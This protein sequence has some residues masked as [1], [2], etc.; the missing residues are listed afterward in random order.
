MDQTRPPMKCT[1][2]RWD[3]FAKVS[4]EACRFSDG[5]PTLSVSIYDKDGGVVIQAYGDPCLLVEG[6]EFTPEQVFNVLHSLA[7]LRKAGTAA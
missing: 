6:S 2:Q 5:T 7:A 3:H 1:Y 4:L